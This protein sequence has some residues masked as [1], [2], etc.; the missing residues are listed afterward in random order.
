MTCYEFLGPA[1]H[2]LMYD[3]NMGVLECET[4]KCYR[5][6]ALSPENEFFLVLIRLHLGLMEQDLADCFE[7]SQ[8][9]VSRIII[10]WINFL[11]LK[12]KEIPIIFIHPYVIKVFTNNV[13]F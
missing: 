4:S 1:V 7:I 8:S 11:F 6:R 10:T 2:S 9:T 12:L 5:P 13:C 3:A